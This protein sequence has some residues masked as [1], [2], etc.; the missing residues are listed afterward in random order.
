MHYLYIL[1]L[2]TQFCSGLILIVIVATLE[3][4]N[5]GLT[6]QIGSTVASSFKGKV[7]REE[8]MNNLTRRIATVFMVVSILVAVGANRW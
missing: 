8:R 3:S 1:L 4:K 6:G 5:E 7:G 2:A